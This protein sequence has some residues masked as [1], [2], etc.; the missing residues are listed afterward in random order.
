MNSQTSHAKSPV[1]EELF[2]TADKC[3]SNNTDKTSHGGC[4]NNNVAKE[5]GFIKTSSF[6]KVNMDGI[7][8]GRKVDLNAHSCYAALARALDDMFLPSAAV[9]ARRNFLFSLFI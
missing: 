1:T 8:I 6:V 2:S 7:P 4:T 5:K 9:G 3:K